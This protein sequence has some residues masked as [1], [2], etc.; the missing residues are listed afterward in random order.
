MAQP[1][2]ELV[3]EAMARHGYWAVGLTLLLENAGLPLPGETVLLLASFLAYSR[4]ELHMPWIIVIAICAATLGDNIGFFIG[5][6]GG[7]LFLRRYQRTLRI[8]QHTIDKGERIFAQYGAATIFFARF[9]FGLRVIA[10]PLA[11]V[12]R[13]PW[14]RFAI[15]NVLGATFWVFVITTVG[16]RFG[17]HWDQL[18]DFV[19][20]LNI[21]VAIIAALVFVGLWYWR[22]TRSNSSRKG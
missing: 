17:K 18:M 16:Y 21:I 11:G 13:M 8:P 19:R 20:R 15:F 10:G 2:V 1:I 14:K 12:L 9:I 3:R 6:R 22:R 5:D 7:H 4:H